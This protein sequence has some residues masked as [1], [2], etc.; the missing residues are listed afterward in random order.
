MSFVVIFPTTVVLL[1]FVIPFI[2]KSSYILALSEITILPVPLASRS[3]LLLLRVVLI[4]FVSI[5][6]SSNNKADPYKSR[7]LFVINPKSK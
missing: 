6:I 4:T 2:V 5:L 1:K 7:H 3:K